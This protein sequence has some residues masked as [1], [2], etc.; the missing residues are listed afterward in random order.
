MEA[1]E[2]SVAKS[3]VTPERFA[4]GMTFDQYMAFIGTPGNL[5]RE[6]GCDCRRRLEH[7][8]VP[9]PLGLLVLG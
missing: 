9:D 4:K 7:Q 5:E 1:Q 2:E 8:R 6:A 3:V